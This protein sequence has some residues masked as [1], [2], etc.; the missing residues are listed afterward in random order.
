MYVRVCQHMYMHSSLNV[1]MHMSTYVYV[2]L[3]MYIHVTYTY[4]YVRHKGLMARTMLMARTK[5]FYMK[6]KESVDFH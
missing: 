6:I 3:H 1:C 2:Y 4:V 5:G